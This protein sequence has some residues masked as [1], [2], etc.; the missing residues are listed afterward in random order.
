MLKSRL[1]LIVTFICVCENSQAT[2]SGVRF[3]GAVGMPAVT[4][5][6]PNKTTAG[7]DGISLQGRLFTPIVEDSSINIL[8]QAVLRY[9]DL[10]NTQSTDAET[11]V[12]NHIGP[13]L[14][15]TFTFARLS[16]GYEYMLMKARH[17]YIGSTG[18]QIE[19]DYTASNIFAGITIPFGDL[20][21]GFSYNYATG[22]AGK[23]ETGLTKDSDYTEQSIWFHISYST[24]SALGDLARSLVKK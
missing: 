11:E 13:G 9:H 10:K 15:L 12:A 22:K 23:G 20:G 6:N 8:A 17:Y 7:Y 2:Q 1:V 24:G 21:I 14:G 3:D 4:I 16:L 5:T 18:R 19:F